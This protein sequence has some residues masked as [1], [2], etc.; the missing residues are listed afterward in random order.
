MQRRIKYS[1][2][3]RTGRCWP[4][5][6]NKTETAGRNGRMG[7]PEQQRRTAGQRKAVVETGDR[8]KR[9]RTYPEGGSAATRGGRLGRPYRKS[10]AHSGYSRR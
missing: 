3:L 8:S 6:D 10:A 2:P 4:L 1:W 7:R 9:R 5:F